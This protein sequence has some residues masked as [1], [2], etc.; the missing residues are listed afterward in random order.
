MTTTL[1]SW[2][3][4]RAAGAALAAVLV[5][6]MTGCA[7]GNASPTPPASSS[8][9]SPSAALPMPVLQRIGDHTIAAT[10]TDTPASRQFAAMLPLSLQMRDVWGQAK[11]GPLPQLLTVQGG[12]PV[13]DPTAGDLYYWPRSGVIA[14]YYDDLGQAVPDP[15]LVRLGV[16]DTGLD[17]L[18]NAGQRFTVGIHP[19]TATSS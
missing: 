12:T 2:I 4:R 7:T 14:V 11:S 8:S 18:A 5:A 6:V 13:H 19:A 1:T 17:S 3:R 9:V 16:V 10:L 15:G